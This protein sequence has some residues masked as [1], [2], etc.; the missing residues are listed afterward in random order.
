MPSPSR[1]LSREGKEETNHSCIIKEHSISSQLAGAA[2][3]NSPV[4][5]ICCLEQHQTHWLTFMLLE[6]TKMPLKLLF[7]SA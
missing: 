7:I 2:F 3:T 1:C 4:P 5:H 6:D